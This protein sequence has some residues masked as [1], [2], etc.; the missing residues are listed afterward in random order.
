MEWNEWLNE[1]IMIIFK[2]LIL[3]RQLS[4]VGTYFTPPRRLHGI[5]FGYA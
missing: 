4:Y 2:I 3:P 5:V 1:W